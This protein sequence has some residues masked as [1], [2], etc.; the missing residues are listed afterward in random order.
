MQKKDWKAEQQENMGN[1][2]GGGKDFEKVG[3]H[4]KSKT[5]REGHTSGKA[6]NDSE[7]VTI[8]IRFFFVS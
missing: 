5:T 3:K 6:G 8:L 2:S 7:K 4:E 1:F